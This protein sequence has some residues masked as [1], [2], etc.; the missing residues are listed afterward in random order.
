MATH[1]IG[2]PTPKTPPP[3]PSALPDPKRRLLDI[4]DVVTLPSIRVKGTDY[5]LKT[6]EALS[7]LEDGL[8]HEC[9]RRILELDSK[10][11]DQEV[12]KEYAGLLD[13]ICR[14]VIDGMTD[15]EHQALT[16]TQRQS[17]VVTFSVLRWG[18]MHEAT[19]GATDSPESPSTPENSSPS[20]A[21]SIQD[22]I[23]SA[24]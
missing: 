20:S 18:T 16:D 1:P 22:P 10:P 5:G 15:D 6:R 2:P 14:L 21:A 3:H 19:A 7:M 8:A 4:G 9:Y 12:A 17:I 11:F 24:G 13:R 23:L